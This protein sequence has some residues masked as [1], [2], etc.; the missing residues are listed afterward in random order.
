MMKR[1]Y[2]SSLVLLWL[3]V[4]GDLRAQWQRQYPLAKLDNVNDIVVQPDGH[5]FAVGADDILLRWTSATQS[6]DL[7]PDV[8][9]GWTFFAVDYLNNTNGTFVAAGGTGLLLSQDAGQSWETVPGTPAGVRAVKILPSTHVIV[10]ASNGVS[11]WNNISW[12][13]LNAPV[14]SGITGGFIL[15]DQHIWCFTAGATPVIYYTSNGGTDWHQNTEIA[16]PD[17]VRFYDALNGISLD[18]RIVYKTV[19]G[20]VHW[21]EISNNAIHNSVND[22]TYGASP[23][24]LMAATFNGDPSLSTDGGVT[25]TQQDMGLIN[26]RNFS[27]AAIND[28]IFW[29]GNDLTSIA[30]TTDAG[31]TWEERCGPNR[32]ILYDIFFLNRSIGIAVGTK[33]IIL[34]TKDG[35][36]HWEDVT[37]DETRINWCVQGLAVN[38]LWI[39]SSQ[40]IYHSVDTGATWVEK[41]IFPAGGINDIVA[42]SNNRILACSSSGIIYRTT[43]AGIKWDTV[44]QTNA[45][46]RSIAKIDNQRYMATGFNGLVLRSPDQGDTWTPLAVPTAGLQYEQ[47]YFVSPQDGWLI[48]S[49]FENEMWHTPDAG[50]TWEPITLPIDRFWQGVYFITPDTGV[51]VCNSTGEGRAYIT[52]NGGQNWQSGYTT[53]F[54]LYGV[55]GIPNPNGT[56]WIHGY[57]SDIEILPYC[58]MLPVINNFA[59]DVSPCENDT[60]T[61]SITSQD[62]DQFY[63]LFPPGWQIVGNGN[64]DTVQV[65][66]GKNVGTISVTGTN[67]CGFTNPIN[68]GAGPILLPEISGITGPNSP[69]ESVLISYTAAAQN[70]DDFTWTFPSINWEVFGSSNTQNIQVLVGEEPG[71]ITV[72]GSNSCGTTNLVTLNVNPALRPR[73][74]QVLGNLAPCEGSVEEYIAVS[75]FYDEIVWTFP[76]DW[77]ILGPSDEPAISVQ[78]G[79]MSGVVSAK[80]LNECGESA[81]QTLDATALPVPAVSVVVVPEV[82][83]FLTASEDGIS[84]QWYFNGTLIPGAN[85]KSYTATQLGNYYVIVTYANGCAST[86]NTVEVMSLA[87]APG[88]PEE[89]IRVNPV[90]AS[91][92]LIISG[93]QAPVSFRIT[94]MNGELLKKGVLDK[95]TLDLQDIQAGMYLLRLD[96]GRQIVL[97][98]FVVVK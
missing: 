59:G 4:A 53:S 79:V 33:G 5:A 87:I 17:V 95:T 64:N 30:R 10:V 16:R 12:T 78:V 45:Q 66:V 24:V 72:S 65:K 25:W 29:M 98:R 52:F 91:D 58:N 8:E 41:G 77:V 47:T 57:S 44:F 55:S 60:V 6:W 21:T 36:L 54:Q 86:S 75:Q 9:K 82:P 61:Y 20:G 19:D 7:L 73:T 35:G 68:V 26:Q 85:A 83:Q 70:I 28:S 76:A 22:I 46:I 97:R 1:V 15:D 90:P 63:W 49:S 2:F 88:E 37:F 62:V 27:V 71:V 50:N 11:R 40:R 81:I 38:D 67:A 3:I 96:T 13:S 14:T 89:A 56:A 32:K 74:T 51:V 93:L 31:V 94:G 80:A 92:Q 69:C 42:I 18:N 43:N 34:R 23:N 39:G 48:T 84:Y